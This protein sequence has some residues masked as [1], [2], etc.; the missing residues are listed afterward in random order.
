MC[1]GVGS[2]NHLRILI[3]AG[4]EYAEISREM[5]I[6]KSFIRGYLANDKALRQFWHQRRQAK[7]RESHR[8]ALLGLLEAHP[9]VPLKKIRLIPRNGFS[10]L[11]RNDKDWLV[12]NLPML[13]TT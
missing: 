1:W 2:E 11:A 8:K 6:K 3:Q 12:Q 13:R 4:K 10:W 9:G 5:G 7:I